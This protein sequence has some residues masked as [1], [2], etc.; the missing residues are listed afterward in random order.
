M[1]IEEDVS[2]AIDAIEDNLE[3]GGAGAET[4]GAIKDETPDI[5]KELARELGW[6]DKFDGDPSEYVDAATYIRRSKEINEAKRSQISGL[7]KQLKEINNVVSELKTHNER[8]YKAEVK[9]LTQEL[10]GLKAQRR[11]AIEDGD[12]DRVEKIEKQMAETHELVTESK[13]AAEKV[14]DT[15]WSEWVEG[16]PWYKEDDEMR[17]FADK[18]GLEYEGLPFDKILKHV[19]KDVKAEFPE[20]FGGVKAKATE[21]K[22][23]ISPVESGSRKISSGRTKTESDLTP[24]QRSVMNQFVRQGVMTKAE[25]IADLVK[26]GEL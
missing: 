20:K 22:P 12:V 25:Y 17:A 21:K 13:P 26:V 15:V 6:N 2:S 18:A 7:K 1:N 23:A 4:K 16:N 9:R 8:V 5:V 14:S 24:A 10:D 3:A 11:A 19:L